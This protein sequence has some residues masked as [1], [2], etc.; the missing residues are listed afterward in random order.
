MKKMTALIL[1]LIFLFSLC[2]CSITDKVNPENPTDYLDK[3]YWG[4]RICIRDNSKEIEHAEIDAVTV[5]ETDLDTEIYDENLITVTA[6]KLSYDETQGP[7]IT[8]E[9]CNL[10]EHNVTVESSLVI[11]NGWIIPT[12]FSVEVPTIEIIDYTLYLSESELKEFGISEICQV[13]FKIKVTDTDDGSFSGNSATTEIYKNTDSHYSNFSYC[14]ELY[15]QDGITLR[16]EGTTEKDNETCDYIARIFI[17]NESD[18][19][20]KVE[21]TDINLEG[22]DTDFVCSFD[23][24]ANSSGYNEL[25]FDKA[26]LKEYDIENIKTIFMEINAY[27]TDNN[28]III[29]SGSTL[30]EI[31]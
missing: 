9:L 6:K 25:Y 26:T 28:E 15:S 13:E 22:K 14:E 18:R 10:S 12:A 7:A 27:F 2:A 31:M 20:A 16:M 1:T 30:Y 19:D 23:A 29:D 8:F 5:Y 3:G 11:I 4:Q 21:F 24:P 17:L